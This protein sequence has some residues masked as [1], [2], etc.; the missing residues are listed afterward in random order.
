VGWRWLILQTLGTSR[1]TRLKCPRVI[2]IW[3]GS[4]HQAVYRGSLTC[5]DLLEPSRAQPRRPPSLCRQ[6]RTRRRL[7]PANIQNAN[8]I[9]FS[10]K[11]A[12]SRHKRKLIALLNREAIF[13]ASRPG[14]RTQR[15]TSADYHDFKVATWLYSRTCPRSR[16]NQVKQASAPRHPQRGA[17]ERRVQAARSLRDISIVVRHQVAHCTVELLLQAKD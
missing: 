13:S 16:S 15:T 1:K 4:H 10:R 7:Q 6:L 8:Q 9:L 14:G 17:L 3:E 11:K 2:F 5:R 12:A